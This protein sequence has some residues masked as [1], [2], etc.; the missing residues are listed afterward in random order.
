MS[1]PTARLQEKFSDHWKGFIHPEGILK[2]ARV[3][4]VLGGQTWI[5]QS[6]TTDLRYVHKSD[7]Q[8][9]RL[10]HFRPIEG[11]DLPGNGPPITV[12][13][14]GHD[15]PIRNRE[16]QHSL[17]PATGKSHCLIQKATE[18]DSVLFHLPASILVVYPNE[19]RDQVEWARRAN[20]L[21]PRLQFVGGPPG[22]GNDEGIGEGKSLLPEAPGQL[23]RPAEVGVHLFPYG[24]GVT[25]GQEREG[26]RIQWLNAYRPHVGQESG[27]HQIEGEGE[28]EELLRCIVSKTG[29]LMKE[30][31]DSVK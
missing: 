8:C 29:N 21:N 17:W 4:S 7:S 10:L 31:P 28:P 18:L 5:P 6:F 13:G 3:Q 23:S 20:I 1:N 12:P 9:G 26:V 25:Q 22:L 27:H 2:T 11:I 16:N 19:E 15:A 24:V 30:A 14:E